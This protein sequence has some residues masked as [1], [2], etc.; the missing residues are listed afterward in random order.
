M[1]VALKFSLRS[2]NMIYPALL[3]FLKIVLTIQAF[4]VSTQIKI[5]LLLFCENTVGNLMG[6]A[7]NL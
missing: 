5:F 4:S 3:F 7:L 2:G 1:T 6:V